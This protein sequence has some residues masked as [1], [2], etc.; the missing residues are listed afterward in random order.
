MMCYAQ[1][2]PETAATA[3]EEMPGAAP[4]RETAGRRFAVAERRPDN[5]EDT[6]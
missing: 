2:K 5:R 6:G 4:Q 3:E 1:D